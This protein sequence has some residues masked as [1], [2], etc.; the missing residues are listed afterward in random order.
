MFVDSQLTGLQY[1]SSDVDSSDC[2]NT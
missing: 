2:C 1:L